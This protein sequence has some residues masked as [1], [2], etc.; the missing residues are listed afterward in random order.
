MAMEQ[1]RFSAIEGLRAWLAWAVVLTHLAWWSGLKGPLFALL[2]GLGFPA[3]TT[4]MIVS[5]FVITH[6]VLGRPEP[7]RYYLLR[8][9][10]RLYPLFVVTCVLGYFAYRLPLQIPGFNPE[11]AQDLNRIVVNTD[12]NFWGHVMAH[13]TML[14]GAVPHSLLP[15]SDMAFNQ[16]AWTISLEWQF[17]ILAPFIV[18]LIVLRPATAGVV[19]AAFFAITQWML[20]HHWLGSFEHSTVFDMG[21]YFAVGIASRMLYPTLAD[22]IENAGAALACIIV[23]YS[24]TR[25]HSLAVW[26]VIY[27]G[28]LTPSG[29]RP[30][31]WTFALES[32]VSQYFGSRSYSVFLSH[33]LTIN[34][35]VWL[36]GTAPGFVPLTLMVVP[37]T[38]VLSEILYRYVEFP[39]IALGAYWCESSLNLALRRSVDRA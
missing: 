11:F 9:F 16:F 24:L 10:M 39:G 1:K 14:Y 17:Y 28:L 3:V 20:G 5:G 27:L 12:Q 33:F 30:S 36:W 18:S 23:F 19:L 8:R 4:F 38:I 13:A 37:S 22:R 7:Y 34:S 21:G 2:D 31:V 29:K 15:S 35:A 26:S 25:Q 32:P 6:L